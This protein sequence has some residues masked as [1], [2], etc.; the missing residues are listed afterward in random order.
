MCAP[1]AS[2]VLPTGNMPCAMSFSRTAGT[3]KAA[4]MS[5][6]SLSMAL[7][8]LPAGATRPNQTVVSMPTPDSIS[9]GTS[10]SD[11]MRSR[12]AVAIARS[13][14]AATCVATSL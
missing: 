10:L 14:P 8:G 9:V 12:V 13:F 1:N 3:F 4:A 2:E 7:F 6:W 11:S 5:A